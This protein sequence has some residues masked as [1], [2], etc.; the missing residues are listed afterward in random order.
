M[1]TRADYEDVGS[2]CMKPKP[3]LEQMAGLQTEGVNNRDGF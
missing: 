2:S 3:N 1:V